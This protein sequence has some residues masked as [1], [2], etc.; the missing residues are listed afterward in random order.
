M[1]NREFFRSRW[2]G[3]SIGFCRVIGAVNEERADWT[4]DPRSRSA[5]RLVAHLIGHV[6]DLNEL[7]DDA[8]IH[9]RNE[10]PFASI[11]EAVATFR[12]ESAELDRKLAEMSDEDWIKPSR[13]LVDEHEIMAAPVRDA[14]WMLLFDSVHHRGQL[15]T[16][17]RAI[18]GKCP[19]LYGPSADEGIAH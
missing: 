5:R 10:V 9:H 17:L 16:H 2:A 8:V 4:P 19:A 12:D 11:V 18:G 7:M 1:S 6:Q 15:T 14:A 13:F 3:E